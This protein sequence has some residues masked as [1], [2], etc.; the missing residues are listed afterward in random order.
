MK[1][2][3]K[4]Q[5]RGHNLFIT[6][7]PL[8]LAEK[9]KFG[10]VIGGSAHKFDE[11]IEAKYYLEEG[12][13]WLKKK[14]WLDSTG[15]VIMRCHDFWDD[16]PKIGIHGSWA[17]WLGFTEKPIEQIKFYEVHDLGSLTLKDLLKRI[18]PKLKELGQPVFQFIGDLE[19][20]VHKIGLGT[21][22]IT[23]Y[24]IMLQMGADVLLLTDD[25]T[26]LW[27]SGQFAHDSKIPIII[28]NHAV[29][30][31]PGIR[32]LTNYL[33]LNFPDLEIEAIKDVCLTRF[34]GENGEII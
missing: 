6:H 17:K 30:E 14:E 29:A 33:R 27:E 19:Q 26:R 34:F 22:A 9:N 18:Q 28:V 15:M 25:G 20:L 31:E 8:Y 7:E 1:N 24:R 32:A 21:G 13:C 23:D 11:Q 2:L 10:V 12:D 4:A 5:K 3:K 16:F